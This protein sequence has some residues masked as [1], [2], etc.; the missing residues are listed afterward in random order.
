MG[1]I[2]QVL[3]PSFNKLILDKDELEIIYSAPAKTP[4]A[5]PPV[6]QPYSNHEPVPEYARVDPK[7]DC[8]FLHFIL[9]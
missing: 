8:K 1:I 4:V 7:N 5:L 6:L 9:Y 2:L 3:I